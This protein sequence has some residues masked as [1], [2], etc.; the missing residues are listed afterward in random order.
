VGTGFVAPGSPRDL[1]R[2]ALPNLEYPQAL[3]RGPDDHPPPAGLGF[4]A[5]SWSPRLG[6]AGTYDARWR[7]ERC[8]L[9]PE[10]FDPRFH[11]GAPTDQVTTQPLRGGERVTLTNVSPEGR[12]SF[13]LPR[14]TIEVEATI[15]GTASVHAAALDTVV[16][17]PDD[18]R[19]LLCWRATIPC[20]R[21]FLY[22]EQ[23]EV[24]AP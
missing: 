14:S 16:I 10:D 1:E 15:K 21:D 17:E 18:A 3:I 24:R 22:I 2:V 5:R 9:L 11:Q 8:P 12:L 20:G 19:C 13:E 4:V 6:L 7:R 23:V